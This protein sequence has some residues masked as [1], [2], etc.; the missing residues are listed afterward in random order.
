M[1]TIPRKVPNTK[2]TARLRNWSRNQLAMLS[3]V[4]LYMFQENEIPSDDVL[5]IRIELEPNDVTVYCE[6]SR[7]EALSYSVLVEDRQ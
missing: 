1:N 2:P 6:D 5:T 7:Q 3:E 4:L